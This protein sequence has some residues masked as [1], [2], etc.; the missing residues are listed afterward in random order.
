LCPKRQ[1]RFL[2]FVGPLPDKGVFWF[3]R[4]ASELGRLRPDI[5]VLVVVGRGNLDWLQKTGMNLRGL[6]NFKVM[7]ATSDPRQF[8]C[9]TRVLLAPSLWQEAFLRV[10]VEG[11]LNGIPTLASRRGA[12]EGTLGDSGFVFDI[13]EQYT[14][15]EH[16]TPEAAEV[17]PWVQT[18]IR[19]WDDA[20]FYKE[21]SARSLAE[22]ARYSPEIVI[23]KHEVVLER[24]MSQSRPPTEPLGP[25]ALD[26]APLQSLFSEPM[27]LNRFGELAVPDDF[28][29]S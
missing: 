15:T 16:R 22:S 29:L 24:A 2:T 10:A 14:S 3:A 26:L 4:I 13:P 19:L 9:L 12:L 21:Q 23:P 28:I 20:E 27:G 11:M 25:L 17:A 7:P 6:P 5:P 18:V 8:L 1:P